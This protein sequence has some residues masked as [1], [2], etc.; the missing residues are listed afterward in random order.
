M[1]FIEYI[2]RGLSYVRH[3][4]PQQITINNITVLPPSSL[5]ENRVALITGGASGIGK[6]I[7][8]AF[9]DAGATVVITGRNVE[10]LKSVAA[11][12]E[13]QYPERI[14]ISKMDVSN[15]QSIKYSLD[16]INNL[17]GVRNIDI[18]VNN[19]G[20][21]GGHISNCTEEEFGNIIDT[22][23]KGVFFLSKM[24]AD[25]MIRNCVGGNI[26]MIASSSSLRP[27]VSAYMLSKWGVRGLT[28]GLAKMYV[29]H[30]IV[31]NGVAPGP[32]ATPMMIKSGET[33]KR[34]SNNPSGRF[35]EPEEIG[36]AAV[37]LTSSMGKMV[38]GDILYMTGGSGIITF[39][40][41]QY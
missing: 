19:A 17:L 24:L 30:G 37:F 35:A 16:N 7:A 33:N 36:N 41:V 32:T 10:K 38:V 13:K 39:D 22:N 40:D 11:D 6:S 3:G 25:Q 27:A 1:K 12:F 20:V 28:E 15:I 29:K 18:L 14:L 5:L 9:L 21:E 8:K 23:L 34:L 26:L 31:V 2:R 4:V